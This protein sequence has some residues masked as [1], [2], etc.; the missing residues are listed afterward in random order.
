MSAA[1]SELYRRIWA[2]DAA[3]GTA[4]EW[5]RDT[6]THR[7]APFLKR[8]NAPYPARVIDLGAGD[9]RYLWSMIE[10]GVAAFTS[11]GV[12]YV[13]RPAGLYDT[14][15]W[16]VQDIAHPLV[17]RWDV[18]FSADTL[19][20]LPIDDVAHALISMSRVAPLSWARISL[21]HD[22]YGTQRG[23]VLHETVLP[24][25]EWLSMLSAV[26]R[27]RVLEY[28]VYLDLDGK[29]TALEVGWRSNA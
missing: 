5:V 27:V 17:G 4:A 16:R 3:Y 23:L 21:R 18:A 19:E 20:H 29:E 2:Q 11:C 9:G 8:W 14:I 26:H 13:D 12:D 6:V 15:E 10:H 28:R 1:H 22:T 7:L 25:W 24:S